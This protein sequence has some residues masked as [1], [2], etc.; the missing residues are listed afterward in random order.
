MEQVFTIPDYRRKRQPGRFPASAKWPNLISQKKG[1]KCILFSRKDNKSRYDIMRFSLPVGTAGVVWFR[2]LPWPSP[3]RPP[4]AGCR[5][6]LMAGRERPG[7]PVHSDGNEHRSSRVTRSVGPRFI[8]GRTDA[9]IP[10]SE[11]TRDSGS[12][13]SESPGRSAAGGAQRGDVRGRS[14]RDST[15]LVCGGACVAGSSRESSGMTLM[16][17][18][19]LL[20]KCLIQAN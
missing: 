15:A 5:P 18:Q 20:T 4:P 16:A 19:E 14:P 6:Y 3:K 9:F 8:T 11:R 7:G 17:S 12:G 2:W 13:P 10:E 1:L